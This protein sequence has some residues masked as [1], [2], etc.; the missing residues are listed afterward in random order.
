[1]DQYTHDGLTFEV[2]DAGPADGEVIVLLHGFPQDRRSW[3]R[4]E[5]GLHQAGYRTL[6]PDQRGYSPAARPE[7]R[8]HYT[9]GA[10]AADVIA[11]LDAAGVERAH[12]VGHDWGGGVAWGLGAQHADRFA[13]LTVIST[14]HPQAMVRAALRGQLVRSWYMFAFQLPVIPEALLGMSARR[15]DLARRLERSGLPADAA[16]HTQQRALE[17]GFLR[18]AIDWYRGLPWSLR[19]PVGRIAIPTTYI[20]GRHDQFLS[21]AAAES[22]A[23]WVTAEYRFV[24]VDG[25]H[26]LPENQAPA[27]AQLILERVAT[28]GDRRHRTEAGVRT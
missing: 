11:L 19:E 26:W 16:A 1:M 3:A 24:E 17:P 27:M 20:W 5:P 28:G 13:S 21:R 8:R 7:G 4:I 23:S 9:G 6:A 25:D 2:R 12:L 14:P 18:G 10:L 22:T 15:G